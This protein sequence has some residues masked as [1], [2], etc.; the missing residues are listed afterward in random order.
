MICSSN[1][2]ATIYRQRWWQQQTE[3][4]SYHFFSF[5]V[6]YKTNSASLTNLKDILVYTLEYCSCLWLFAFLIF[7]TV[8]PRT[9]STH[10][11]SPINLYTKYL[12]LKEFSFIAAVYLRN[13]PLCMCE[14]ECVPRTAFFY[15]FST[16][17]TIIF[18]IWY[19]SP[20]SF[21]EIRTGKRYYN[22]NNV[23]SQ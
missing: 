19:S 13:A 15:H 4:D 22:L 2:N 5:S 16:I 7:P 9:H 21:V 6:K 18:A 11:Y 3:D 17:S 12:P 8:C 23:L 10:K 14:C 1:S 20:S